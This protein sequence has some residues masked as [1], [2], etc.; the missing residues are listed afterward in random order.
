MKKMKR[1]RRSMSSKYKS[2]LIFVFEGAKKERKKK[3]RSMKKLLRN[4]DK[5]DFNAEKNVF[6]MDENGRHA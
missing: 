3:G 6:G 2:D 4:T 5:R 1:L